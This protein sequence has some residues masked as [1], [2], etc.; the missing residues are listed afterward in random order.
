MARHQNNEGLSARE[1]ARQMQ[2]QQERRQKSSSVLLRVAVVVIAIAV[3]AGLTYFVIQQRQGGDTEAATQGEAPSAANEHAGVTLTSATEFVD[4]DDLGE[5]DAEDVPGGDGET[6]AGAQAR[7]EGEAPHLIIYADP[8][9]VHCADFEEQNAEQIKEWVDSGDLTVEY[10]LVTYLDRGSQT[11][12]S[13]RANNAMMAVAEQS[14]E[15]FLDYM[16]EIFSHQGTELS[17]DELASIAEDDFGVDI[18]SAVDE[19]TYRAF[20]AYATA[21]AQENG[22]EGTPT[23]YLD[24]ED[25]SSSETAFQEWA[26]NAIDEY[27][28][29]AA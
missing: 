19:G 5:V 7:E 28:D 16:T 6:P 1:R 12:Y 9:C 25:W 17:N 15:N 20:A 2:Q 18:S 29:E 26:Q 10:R 24:D 27:Q 22:V 11:N 14:P 13:A 23:V 8:A 3:V 21:D 4:G